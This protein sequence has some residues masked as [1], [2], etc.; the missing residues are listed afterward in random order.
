[1]RTIKLHSVLLILGIVLIVSFL[2]LNCV[3]YRLRNVYFRTQKEGEG[4]GGIPSGR[5]ASIFRFRLGCGWNHPL[6]F[7]QALLY[8]ARIYNEESTLL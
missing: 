5:N 4:A 3:S 6:C 1:M 8:I 2:S 7:S